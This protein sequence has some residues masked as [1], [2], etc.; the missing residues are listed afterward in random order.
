MVAIKILNLDTFQDDVQDVQREIMLLSQLS[1]SDVQNVTRYHTSFLQGS[2]LWIIMDYCSGGSI[3]TLLKAGTIE[4]KYSAVIMREVLIVLIYIHKEG[5]IH[6]DIK[7]ANI[8][9]TNEGR[10][11][12]CDFGVAAQLSTAQLRRT[13]MIGTPYWMAPEVIQEGAGYNQK[14]D[15]WSLG[16][17]LYE[18]TTGHPPY[19]EQEVTR[20]MH[21]IPRQKPARL[22]GTQYSSALKEFVA[23]CLDEQPEER[24][25]AEE[26][27]KTKFIKNTKNVPTQIIKDLILR[28]Q[29]WKAQNKSRCNS[30]LEPSPG[31]AVID[32]DEDDA[33]SDSVFWD[34]N[35]DY[36]E[37]GNTII[38][39]SATAPNSSTSPFMPEPP[40]SSM[41]SP[42]PSQPGTLKLNSP[43]P[44]SSST[45][46]N[47]TNQHTFKEN[48]F[49]SHKTPESSITEKHPLTE[50]FEP[51]KP[52]KVKEFTPSIV[53]PIPNNVNLISN[54]DML[55]PTPMPS[56]NPNH[57]SMSPNAL[58]S[59]I[60][61]P[62]MNLSPSASSPGTP[63]LQNQRVFVPPISIDIPSFD[64][65]Y[66]PP[67]LASPNTPISS[68]GLSF[69]VQSPKPRNPVTSPMDSPPPVTPH[70]PIKQVF[71]QNNLPSNIGAG[72]KPSSFSS[73]P[74]SKTRLSALAADPPHIPT[75]TG[76]TTSASDQ[77]LLS[78]NFHRK[79]RSVS[80]PL[81]QPPVRSLSAVPLAATSDTASNMV[82]ERPS[83]SSFVDQ[84]AIQPRTPPNL[85][86]PT[87]VLPKF[88]DL[89]SLNSSFLLDENSKQSTIS[90]LDKLLT[91]FINGLD[92]LEQDLTINFSSL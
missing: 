75:G 48:Y 71:S 17:T 3:R 66:P 31:T 14:A 70:T 52:L 62:H 89:P 35:D 39:K 83:S 88:P 22:E 87:N 21:L 68:D 10:V 46:Y 49:M 26:L 18:I 25:T 47:G 82:M 79:L 74:H 91:V 15:I 55:L 67:V 57:A 16:V 64:K 37:N 77:D 63:P 65:I 42:V 54:S 76:I 40:S 41:S 33:D 23:K 32:D 80:S 72:S 45:L 90:E 19:A 78:L 43:D 84:K 69:E 1:Q 4:E 92:A 6:R 9:V 81:A 60:N 85:H 28:Y 8:L 29:K 2:K 27:Y 59:G 7:A 86:T 13:S 38:E 56:F 30:I 20:A 73:R 5:I 58:H 24:A 11:Q 51:E 12:L 61:S 34:F 44:G 53:S 50:L 36:D